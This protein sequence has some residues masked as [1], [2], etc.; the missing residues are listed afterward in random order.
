M[1]VDGN[2]IRLK[3]SYA[4]PVAILVGPGAVSTGDIGPD[5][6]ARVSETNSWQVGEGHSYLI[7][8]DLPVDERVWLTPDDVAVGKDTVV[9]AAMTWIHQLLGH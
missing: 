8:T 2:K 7:H 3:E 9:N 4:G 6:F 1:D 5:Y